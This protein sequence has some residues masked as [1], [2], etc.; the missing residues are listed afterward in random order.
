MKWDQGYRILFVDDDKIFGRMFEKWFSTQTNYKFMHARD[1]VA[2]FQLL[3]ENRFDVVISNVRMPGMDGLEFTKVLKE[4]Y[5]TKVIIYTAGNFPGERQ[6]AFRNGAHARLFKP[7]SMEDLTDFIVSLLNNP[8][9]YIGNRL[10]KTAKPQR[11][12]HGD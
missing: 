12:L 7:V 10:G 9:R 4:K 6:L 5:D 3:D 8:I 1:S 2:G 11:V